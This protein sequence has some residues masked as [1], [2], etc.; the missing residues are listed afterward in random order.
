MSHFRLALWLIISNLGLLGLAKEP[1]VVPK[2]EA[3]KPVV[4][5]KISAV[6]G[7]EQWRS[8]ATNAIDGDWQ[9]V[10]TSGIARSMDAAKAVRGLDLDLGSE[11]PVHGFVYLPPAYTTHG[12]IAE[13]AFYVSKDGQQWG[14]PVVKGAFAKQAANYWPDVKETFQTVMFPK[15]VQGRFVRFDAISEANGEASASIAELAVITDPADYPFKN[16]TLAKLKGTRMAP[17]IHLGYSLPEAQVFYVEA[18]VEKSVDGSYFMAAGWS[19]G[20]FGIQDKG[21][22]SKVAIFSVWDDHAGDNPGAVPSDKQVKVN[23]QGDGVRVGRFGGEGTGNQSF[24]NFDWKVGETY[25]F[26]V[27]A[28]GTEKTTAYTGYLW[29]KEPGKET[30]IWKKLVSFA[31]PRPGR[32]LCGVHS[33]VEDFRRDF[34]SFKEIRSARFTNVWGW[35][36]GKWVPAGQA[37]FTVDGNPNRNIDAEAIPG[38]FRLTTGGDTANKNVRVRRMVSMDKINDAVPTDLPAEVLEFIKNGGKSTPSPIA[39]KTEAATVPK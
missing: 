5:P 18:K 11:K 7:G 31:M 27:T 20:Y 30:G 19:G 28:E 8:P 10:W 23:F 6:R 13:Y 29:I 38:G 1:V 33:F 21:G 32:A 4:A 16:T 35:A 39:P 25:R 34:N 9:T 17:S 2:P 26:I 22:G 3:P 24:F 36:N 15:P 14:E 12:R 37:R